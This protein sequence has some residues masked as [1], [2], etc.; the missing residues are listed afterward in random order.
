MEG[1]DAGRERGREG[2]REEGV[3]HLSACVFC[4]AKPKFQTFCTAIILGRQ[5]PKK[6]PKIG[7]KKAPN[8]TNVY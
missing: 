1:V 3:C 4:L 2:E 7:P 8:G 5:S 6:G